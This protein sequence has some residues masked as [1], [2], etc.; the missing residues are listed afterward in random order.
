LTGGRASDVID[1]KVWP[2]Q[3][4]F[5]TNRRR[6]HVRGVVWEDLVSSRDPLV[7]AGYSSIAELVQLVS[8]WDDSGHDGRVRILFGAEPFNTSRL[9]FKSD[10]KEFTEEAQSYWLEERGISLR[11]SAKV[12]QTI[13]AIES[14]RLSARFVHGVRR[15]HAKLF[16]GDAAATLGSSNFT[17]YGLVTQFEANARFEATRDKARFREVATIAQNFWEAGE[18]WDDGLRELLEALLQVVSWQEALAR[19]CAELL[20]GVWAERYMSGAIVDER[21]LWPSQRSGI[22]EALWITENVGSV[23]VADATGSGKTRM[24]AHLV[25]SVRDRL[26]RTGRVRHD[27]TALVGPPAVVDTWRSEAIGIGLTINTVSHGLLSRA[28]AHGVH[29]DEEALVRRAQILAVDEAH[30][31]LNAGSNRTR[32]IR[33][34][35]ADSVMLFTATPISKGAADLLNLVGLLGPDNFEDSTLEIL[36]RLERRGGFGGA[37]SEGEVEGLRR[38]IQR[39]TVRRTKTQINAMVDSEPEAYTIPETGRH[40]RYPAHSAC[41]YKTAETAGDEALANGVR[42]VVDDLLGIAQLERIIAVPK[43]LGHIYSDEDWLGFRLKSAKGLSRHHVLEALRS[44]RAAAIEHLLGTSEAVQR[45][46]VDPGFKSG[47]TGDVMTKVANA[48]EIGPP[49]IQLSCEVETW[50]SDPDIWRSACAEELGRYERIASVVDQIS[51]ARERGK[52]MQLAQLA[53]KHDRVLAFDR[54]PITLSLLS[55]LLKTENIEG[56]QVL[57]ATSKGSQRK[58]VV[59]TFAPSAEAH[60]IALCSDAMNEGLNLQGAS[61]IVHLDLPTTLRVAE[62]RVGRVDRMDSAHREIEAWW[63]QDGPSFATRA[64]EKLIRRAKES[65]ELLGSNLTLPEFE[66]GMTSTIVEVEAQIEELAAGEG[67]VWDGI[68][69]ALEPVRQMV[70]GPTALIPQDTYDYYRGHAT[71]V[72][73]RVT[74]LRTSRPWAFLSVSA[75]AHGAPRWMLVDPGAPGGCITDLHEVAGRLRDLLAEDPPNHDLDESAVHALE[76]SLDVAI[77]AERRLLPRRMLRA[78]SQMHVV[79]SA[80]AAHARQRS[81]EEEALRWDMLA[82]LASDEV[83][84]VD[85]YLV[86]ERWLALIGPVLAEHRRETPYARYLLLRDVTPRLRRQPMAYVDVEREFTGMPAAVPLDE[87]VS[88]CILGVPDSA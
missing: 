1:A 73:A 13:E 22:A 6:E 82:T 48:A 19:A 83:P 65:E 7:V 10:R 39:F 69:D 55:E 87:R 11:L 16:V 47:D 9:A 8:D 79:L 3:E 32:Q 17:E 76:R 77:T 5:P 26:W 14:G 35:L 18:E 50:L 41:I 52:A 45:F 44:S 68:Q 12:L 38:E 84:K 86:A 46:G 67:K 43:G 25:R 74:P 81:D 58:K 56:A 23:L 66:Q 27:L 40:C 75:I 80:W 51:D 64:Y 61:C 28:T 31:F 29:R 42:P 4:R 62:Q 63:P 54:H 85:P 30:N 20:E 37:L 57:V 33:D 71:R 21:P 70:S 49:E 60:A 59:S 78:L 36:K 24:G 2:A 34:S 88:A 72:L 53:R 15:L